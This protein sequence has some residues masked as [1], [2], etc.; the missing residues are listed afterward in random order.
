MERTID[1]SNFLD[2]TGK[3]TQLSQKNRLRIE[4]LCYLAE[5]FQPDRSYT[6]KEVNSICDEWHTFGDYFLLR[7]ELIDNGLLCR[8][9]DGSRYWKPASE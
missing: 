1:I 9:T 2:D 8:E 7:R 3:I 5:K 4:I 6:E